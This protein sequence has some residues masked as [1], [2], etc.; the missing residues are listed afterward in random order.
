MSRHSY[1]I[2]IAI[3]T[4]LIAAT[5]AQAVVT[6]IKSLDRFQ[7]KIIN[8]PLVVAYIYQSEPNCI[9]TGEICDK[10]YRCQR[11]Q[12]IS[13][14]NAVIKAISRNDRYQAA[15]VHFIQANLSKNHLCDLKESYNLTDEDSLILFDREKEQPTLLTGKLNRS[16]VEN[17]IEAQWHSKIDDILKQQAEERK[18]RLAEMRA[19]AIAWGTGPYWC[20]PYGFGGCG[21]N[22]CWGSPCGGYVGFGVGFGGCC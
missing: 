8:E 10:H 7:H 6:P 22:G 9:E 13:H 11:K 12:Q 16:D 18:Q 21:A 14:N 20:W 19:N 17:L 15:G 2:S 5:S 3:I 1:N 4:L